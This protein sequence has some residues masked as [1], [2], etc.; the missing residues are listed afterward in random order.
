MVRTRANRLAFAFLVVSTATAEEIVTDNCCDS[1]DG[2]ACCPGL[3][4]VD[5]AANLPLPEESKLKVMYDPARCCSDGF[6]TAVG[7]TAY[8]AA[9]CSFCRDACDTDDESC[10]LCSVADSSGAE[11][12]TVSTPNESEDEDDFFDAVSDD[13]DDIWVLL[14]GDKFDENIVASQSPG[15]YDFSDDP[16]QYD[17]STCSWDGMSRLEQRIL[18]QR[19]RSMVCDTTCLQDVGDPSYGVTL[20]NYFNA[21]KECRACCHEG[22]MVDGCMPCDGEGSCNS[23]ITKIK[24]MCD[25]NPCEPECQAYVCCSVQW[26]EYS[27][28]EETMHHEMAEVAAKI[29]DRCNLLFTCDAINPTC[30]TNAR[31]CVA[32]PTAVSKDVQQA[33]HERCRELAVTGAGIFDTT[34][35]SAE[36][37]SNE[38]LFMAVDGQQ[39]ALQSVEIDAC[40]VLDKLPFIIE[41]SADVIVA[42]S[43]TGYLAWDDGT[44]PHP[45]VANTGVG[46]PRHVWILQDTT[47]N[48]NHVFIT[49]DLSEHPQ[50]ISS[51]WVKVDSEGKM[52]RTDLTL[53]CTK[54]RKSVRF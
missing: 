12:A 6:E 8:G 39:F 32:E 3:P 31:R 37:F 47:G 40:T 21:G 53:S 42:R 10:V 18:T 1:R 24:N 44:D 19:S 7:C 20:C 29:S 15:S 16:E 35:S 51:D 36:S 25:Q 28:C 11:A 49:V 23:C 38:I 34:Y 17:C 46:C 54:K 50:F 2:N 27:G 14:D 52:S 41:A 30:S 48:Q 26:G 9:G 33:A 4:I 22:F 43:S 45:H 13:T 5:D